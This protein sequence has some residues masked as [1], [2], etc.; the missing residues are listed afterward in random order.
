MIRQNLQKSNFQQTRF[1]VRVTNQYVICQMV[2]AYPTGDVTLASAS[3]QELRGY[4]FNVGLKNFTACYLTGLLLGCRVMRKSRLHKIY[5]GN[6]SADALGTPF[7]ERNLVNQPASYRAILD[8]GLKRPSKGSKIFAAL[9]G[10]TDAGVIV[11]YKPRLF[12]GFDKKKD[13]LN[14]QA[15]SDRIRGVHLAQYA[16]KVLTNDPSVVD[17]SDEIKSSTSHKHFTAF[18]D[19]PSYYPALVDQTIANIR[20]NPKRMKLPDQPKSASKKATRVPNMKKKSREERMHDIEEQKNAWMES[21]DVA[22]S[23]A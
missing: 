18:F 10:V 15:L 2:K 5:K 6:T 13:T 4:K 7:L 21:M 11:P 12:Y 16:A 14:S 8:M 17:Q 22:T 3:S 20:K 1:V 19:N 23:A 9:K